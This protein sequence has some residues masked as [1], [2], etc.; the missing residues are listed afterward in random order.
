VEEDGVPVSRLNADAIGGTARST[1]AQKTSSAA[2]TGILSKLKTRLHGRS[3]SLDF[4]DSFTGM[5][6]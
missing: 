6:P 1:A 4:S 3:G 2:T 5:P